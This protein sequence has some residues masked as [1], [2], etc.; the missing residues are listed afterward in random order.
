MS[1]ANTVILAVI[2][3][4]TSLSGIGQSTR[5]RFASSHSQTAAEKLRTLRRQFETGSPDE[6]QY[7]AKLTSLLAHS[8]NE[9]DGKWPNTLPACQ[10]SAVV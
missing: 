4:V 6:R 1:G 2:L 3:G 7:H 9:D 5:S 8:L 10:K